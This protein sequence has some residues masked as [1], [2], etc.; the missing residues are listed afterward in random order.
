MTSTRA[1]SR[2]THH[3][4][5]TTRAVPSL[6]DDVSRG[7]SDTPRELSPKYFYDDIGS[8]L[9]EAIC[10]TPEYYPTRTEAALLAA[11]AR[12]VIAEVRPNHIIE[13]GSGSS[14]KTTHLLDACEEEDIPACYWPFEVS[15]RIMLDAGEALL[16]RY[17]WLTVEAM[18]GDYTGGLSGLPLPGS[19]RR[20]FVFLGGTIGNF[21]PAAAEALL[22]E[23]R[24]LMRPGDALLLGLDRIKDIAVLEAAYDDTAG[25]TA[26][27]N[28]N[29]LQVL[30]RE[31]GGDFPV[32]AY[33]HEARFEPGA[34]QIEMRLV[35]EH[36]HR[37][38]LAELDMTLDI[39]EGEAIRTEISRKFSPARID[40]LLAAAGLGLRTHYE[41]DDGAYSLVLAERV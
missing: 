10:D 3:H 5:A 32:E 8:Q 14:R 36:A 24:E 22:G 1:G 39:A 23:L 38:Y 35:A 12:A 27:F 33:R 30:N 40:A 16:S 13:L 21:E 4:V 26:A 31:L 19:G 34:E 7:L 17:P 15:T 37:V 9:F 25:H 20:L 18:T 29:V 11:S 6:A 2:L 41:A 28:R